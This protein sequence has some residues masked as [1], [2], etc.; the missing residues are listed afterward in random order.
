MY[1]KFLQQAHELN[2][3][4]DFIINNEENSLSLQRN[5]GII[6]T[7]EGIN[8]AG[9]STQKELIKSSLQQKGYSV[10]LVPQKKDDLVFKKI[11]ERGEGIYFISNP[12][13]DT[14][15]WA[16]YFTKQYED[17]IDRI[18]NSDIVIFDRYKPCFE[19][20]QNF[21]LREYFNMNRAKAERWTKNLLR[22]LPDA[23]MTFLLNISTHEMKI[24]YKQRGNRSSITKKDIQLTKRIKKEYLSRNNIKVINGKR[25]RNDIA[26]GISNDIINYLDKK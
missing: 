13:I 12:I 6:V 2:E 3:L 1:E 25:K 10:F 24:R 26:Y 17:N 22:H 21:L 14:L 16:V 15:D 7:L 8:C 18:T 20:F 19:V 9:K 11:E 5:D 23:D 4:I